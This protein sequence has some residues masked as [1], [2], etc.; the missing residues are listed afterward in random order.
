MKMIFS[1]QVKSWILKFEKHF[2]RC[3]CAQN[4]RYS[5]FT[6]PQYCNLTKDQYCLSLISFMTKYQKKKRGESLE[7]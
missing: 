5:N 2:Q 3:V 6:K 1:I 4:K 7:P